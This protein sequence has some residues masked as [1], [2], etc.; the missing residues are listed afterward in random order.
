MSF[1]ISSEKKNTRYMIRR[2]FRGTFRL[3]LLLR[4]EQL[5][6][7]FPPE[8]ATRGRKKEDHSSLGE[9]VLYLRPPL[10][11]RAKRRRPL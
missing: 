1:L 8:E 4:G 7:Y 11:R 5:R 9:G 6:E 3:T 10:Q 2:K